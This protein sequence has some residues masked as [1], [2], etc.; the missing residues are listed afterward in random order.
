MPNQEATLKHIADQ[1]K[2]SDRLVKLV[3]D[4]FTKKEFLDAFEQVVNIILAIKQANKEEMSAFQK[5]FNEAREMVKSDA[6]SESEKM[7]SKLDAHMA[8]IVEKIERKMST[9]MDGKD[10]DEEAMMQKM[11]ADMKPMHETMMHRMEEIEK[12]L[13]QPKE[14][15]DIKDIEG[16]REELDELRRI[17][18][19]RRLFGGGGTSTIGVQVALGR[20]QV[21]EEEVSFSGTTGTLSETPESGSVRLYRGGVRMQEGTGKDFTISGNTITLAT[22]ALSEEVF[23]ADYNR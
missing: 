16:L 19:Q 7:K 8:Q 23:V 21:I 13:S 4:S 20:I 15:L 12:M 5:M 3:N 6:K 2:F 17:R 18:E 22:A 1:L 11:M 14:P 10:A 9:V